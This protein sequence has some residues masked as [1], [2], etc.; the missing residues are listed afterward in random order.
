VRFKLC[1]SGAAWALMGVRFEH[2]QPTMPVQLICDVFGCGFTTSRESYLSVHQRVHSGSAVFGC[3]CGAVFAKRSSLVTHECKHT[4]ERPFVCSE[5]GCAYATTTKTL[6]DAHVK[7]HR[8]I[9]S[10]KCLVDGCGYASTSRSGL[11]W[12]SRT[13]HD[14]IP[15][16]KKAQKR[17]SHLYR[18]EHAAVSSAQVEEK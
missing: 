17:R 1:D 18:G 8:G 11:T 15:P 5:P 3:T 7:R 4:G 6:L 9:L 16:P 10:H 2:T 14:F 13:T 12:H